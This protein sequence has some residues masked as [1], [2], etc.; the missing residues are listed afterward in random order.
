[1]PVFVLVDL[2]AGLLGV[3]GAMWLRSRSRRHPA[4]DPD[5][6]VVLTDLGTALRWWAAAV[7]LLGLAAYH[8]MPGGFTLAVWSVLALGLGV[9]GA[10]VVGLRWRVESWQLSQPRLEPPRVRVESETWEFALIGGVA[11]LSLTYVAGLV[12]GI[13]QPVHLAISGLEGAVGYGLGLVIWTPRAKIRPIAPATPPLPKESAR[14]STRAP[15]RRPVSRRRDRFVDRDRPD[16]RPDV[17][18]A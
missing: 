4:A 6:Q 16:D 10:A 18:S 5:D 11:G 7:L 17:G 14:A 12:L 1:M 9:V 2:V 13:M 3:V 15:R 8:Q